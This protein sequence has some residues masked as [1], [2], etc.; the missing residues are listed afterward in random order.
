MKATTIKLENG[1]LEDL[2]HACPTGCSISR[3]VRDIL[4]AELERRKMESAAQD[5][6]RFLSNNSEEADEMGTWEA[7]AMERAPAYGKPAL[8]TGGRNR[9]RRQPQ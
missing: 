6:V 1:L 2:E 7:A 3:F 9:R 8:K 4:G 5:Y